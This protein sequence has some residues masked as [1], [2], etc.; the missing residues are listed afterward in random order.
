M[1]GVHEHD[2]VSFI[3]VLI[4]VFVLFEER[5]LSGGIRLS[6]DEFGLLVNVLET[7]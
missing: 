7:T 2:N 3:A 4:E 5:H 1:R 6:R